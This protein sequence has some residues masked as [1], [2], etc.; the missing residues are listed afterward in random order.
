MQY[1][2]STVVATTLIAVCAASATPAQGGR[3][4]KTQEELKQSYQAK[5]KQ[6]WFVDGGWTDDYDQ[7]RERASAEGK[8]IFAYFTRT[9][10]P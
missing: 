4:Q 10:A 6:P 3:P 9:Y 1:T 8:F 7:A 5:R 2:A